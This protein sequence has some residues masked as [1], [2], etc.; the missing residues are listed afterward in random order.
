MDFRAMLQLE[1]VLNSTVLILYV[2]TY[3]QLEGFIFKD[4]G[5]LKIHLPHILLNLNTPLPFMGFITKN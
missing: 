1:R 2:T 3:L 5:T 4:L